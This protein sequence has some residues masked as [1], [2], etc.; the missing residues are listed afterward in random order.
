MNIS[1]YQFS[2][3][4]HI[5]IDVRVPM[6]DGVTLSTDVYLPSK[7]G[8]FPTMLVRTIYDNQSEKNMVTA[9]GFLDEGYAVAMQDCR[10]RFDSHGEFNPYYQEAEDGYD[11]QEWIGSQSWC[12]GNIGMFGGS[13]VGY[14]QSLTAPLRSKYLKAMVPTVSQQ[15]NFGHWRVDGPLQLHVAMNFINMAG[16]TMQMGPRSLIDSE[17]FYR[18]LP[19]ISALDDIADVPFYRACVEHNTYDDFWKGNSLRY[20][21]N[22]IDTPAYIVTGWYDNLVHEGFKLYRGWS[23]EARSRDARQLSKLLVGPWLHGPV[24]EPAPGPIDFGSAAKIDFVKEQVRWNDRRLK[25]VD[26]G[27]DD[28]PPVRIFVMGENVWRSENEWPL[29]RTNYTNYYLH[30]QGSANSLL[31]DGVLNESAPGDEPSDSYTYDPDDPVWTLGGQIMAIQET[32]AGP[33]DRR[34]VERR[35]DVL[36]YSTSPLESDIEVT[37]PVSLTM[38]ASSSATDT[39]FTGTLVDVH[40]DGK[41]IIITEGLL[42]VRYRKSIEETTPIT[43][44]KV[45]EL[46]VDMWETSNVFKAGHCIRLEISSSNFPRFERNLNTG[47]HSAFDSDMQLAHQTIFH[48]SNGPSH[49]VLPIIPR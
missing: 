4:Y 24:G 42:G 8:A 32:I 18:R 15:D 14:T 31:G 25:G 44:G 9:K 19:L 1:K 16:R 29:A 48:D 30:G 2:Q 43:P 27:I 47:K 20:V 45:Y 10:G 5:Q 23:Q 21:Y 13:Y 36:V 46:N 12:D 35:S 40:P 34:P 7:E 17:E 39:D 41:A 33:Q 11:T 37:G 38:Y 6:R 49:L 22:E 26:N 28:E 3:K